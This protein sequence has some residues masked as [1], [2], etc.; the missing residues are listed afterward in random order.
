MLLTIWFIGLAFYVV[1]LICMSL[2]IQYEI[3]RF[4]ILYWAY[5]FT[6]IG[7]L[8]CPALISA[9]WLYSVIYSKIIPFGATL[10]AIPLLL[11][12]LGIVSI[13]LYILFPTLIYDFL[14]TCRFRPSNIKLEEVFS[15][16][17]IFTD[18]KL[19]KKIRLYF[20]S[21]FCFFI[22]A[23]IGE[24]VY[25]L[26]KYYSN[27]I[28]TEETTETLITKQKIISI[29]TLTSNVAYWYLDTNCE[30]VYTTAPSN[31]SKLVPL[32]ENEEYAYLE[33]I[34]IHNVTTT[35]NNNFWKETNIKETQATQ[36]RFHLPK[37]IIEGMFYSN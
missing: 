17:P 9:Q 28:I 23:V 37:E 3:Q 15:P 35:L 29:E 36:Y 10:L 19:V 11:L 31:I 16:Y 20:F 4:K 7:I 33:I 26:P 18:L 8:A 12:L 30:A 25:A 24:G 1:G 22:I 13:A 6:F 2:H 14:S 27:I 34:A 32:T 5:W 21:S